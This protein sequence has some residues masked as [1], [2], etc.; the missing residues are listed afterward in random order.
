MLNSIKATAKDAIIYGLGNI[1]VKIVGLILIPVYTNPEY[2]S[3]DEFGIIGLLEI[4]GMVIISLLTFS[5]PHSFFR[6]YW[7]KEYREN[8]K[9]LFFMTL[10]SQ[11]VIS[12]II[13]A[14][15]IPL[16]GSFS[17]I[18]FGTTDWSKVIV[19]VILSSAF[20]VINNLVNVVMRLQSRPALYSITNILK[21]I[22]VLCLTLFFILSENMGIEGIYFAQLTGN[23]LFYCSCR[24]LLPGTA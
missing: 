17:D 3:I 4:T 10:L 9:G 11:V 19:L 8:Q 22:V 16:S 1:A 5:L 18:L 20:Q 21:L 15:L 12:T 23:I 13:C 24:H 7:D 2:F 14:F 6:W